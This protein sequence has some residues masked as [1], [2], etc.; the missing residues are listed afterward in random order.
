MRV[1]SCCVYFGRWRFS[2]MA[3]TFSQVCNLEFYFWPWGTGDRF[4]A[5]RLF[6]ADLHY[7]L[8]NKDVA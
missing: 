5:A 7:K 6:S 8:L 1:F 3:P 2:S 4:L